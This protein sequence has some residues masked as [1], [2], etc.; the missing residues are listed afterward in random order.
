M[1][2]CVNDRLS[3]TI[4]SALVEGMLFYRLGIS[5]QNIQAHIIA[6]HR[7]TSVHLHPSL[8]LSLCVCVCVLPQKSGPIR[9]PAGRLCEHRHDLNRQDCRR[10]RK[11]RH[12]DKFSNGLSSSLSLSLS[13]CVC[14]CAGA[15]DSA[16]REGGQVVFGGPLLPQQTRRRDTRQY[17]HTHTHTHKFHS[18]THTYPSLNL[19]CVPHPC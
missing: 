11:G 4:S 2:V 12:L 10:L 13:V 15:S 9:P 18:A 19:L 5:Q 3:S 16:A 7:H 14:V 8:S 6:Q 1:C 17:A